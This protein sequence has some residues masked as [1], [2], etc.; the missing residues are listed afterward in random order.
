MINK[1]VKK[2][3]IE[4]GNSLK[5][6]QDTYYAII[7]DD[8]SHK[9]LKFC[10]EDLEVILPNIK[11]YNFPKDK[12]IRLG[13]TVALKSNNKSYVVRNIYKNPNLIWL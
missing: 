3:S 7:Y 10:L 2:I 5:L 4:K 9:N 1:I 11:C 12:S 13:T 8:I 6:R